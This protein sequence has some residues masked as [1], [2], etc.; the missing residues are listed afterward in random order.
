LS[1]GFNAGSRNVLSPA[2][3]F[4]MYRPRTGVT[5]TITARYRRS[6]T[7]A[8]LVTTS[9]FF[10]FQHC[11]HQ[12]VEKAKSDDEAENVFPSHDSLLRPDPTTS[13]N[14]SPRRT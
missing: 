6:L 11:P 2:K 13:R 4:F 1:T 10:R 8:M 7:I 5:A 14:G 3:T 9:D 12:V